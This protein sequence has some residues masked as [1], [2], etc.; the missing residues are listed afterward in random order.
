MTLAFGT[1][2]ERVDPLFFP[3]ARGRLYGCHH[4]A[5]QAGP[6]RV[7][8]VLCPPAGHESVRCHR[9]LRQL[10]LQLAKA[11]H[12]GFRFDYSC[13]GDSEG[14]SSDASLD[15]WRDDVAAAIAETR[16]R[17]GASAV[18]L[19]GLR[20]GA[21][22][23]LQA[24]A[25]RDDVASLV[26]WNPVTDGAT[27]LDEWR[28]ADREFV[29]VHGLPPRSGE[30]LGL[31]LG[32]ALAAALQRL[33]LPL[34]GLPPRLLVCHDPRDRVVLQDLIAHLRPAARTLDVQEA[35]QP[36]IWRQEPLE[37]TVP[38]DAVRGIVTWIGC[39]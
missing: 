13:T 10:A 37:A 25:G 39:E 3:G 9:A 16:R 11:G 30:I 4:A 29:R 7:P 18:V 12:P 27:M 33:A 5:A 23:A 38:F 15:A 32:V 31:P 22:L 19:L 14:E 28:A 1:L 24:A 26:L 35:P 8:V 6:V 2:P 34:T 20:L 21:V 17:T 36:A